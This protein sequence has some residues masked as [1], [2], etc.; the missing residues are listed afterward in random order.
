MMTT[1]YSIAASAETELQAREH[2]TARAA[3]EQRMR[4]LEAEL[5]SLRGEARP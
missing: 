2:A 4:E 5:Q 1:R 3:A